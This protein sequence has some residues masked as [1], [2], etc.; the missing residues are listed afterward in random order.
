[1]LLVLVSHLMVYVRIKKQQECK[2][3]WHL[4]HPKAHWSLFFS[5]GVLHLLLL[6][7]DFLDL[8]VD[9]S[10]WKLLNKAEIC[11]AAKLNKLAFV[12]CCNNICVTSMKCQ[13]RGR[14]MHSFESPNSKLKTFSD[15]LLPPKDFHFKWVQ[16]KE[17]APIKNSHLAHFL[18]NKYIWI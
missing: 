14:K 6:S 9:C 7:L 10:V 2:Q 13:K 3:M 11:T 5:S 12:Q 15:S 18:C 17:K 16:N 4:K 1:M 8:N